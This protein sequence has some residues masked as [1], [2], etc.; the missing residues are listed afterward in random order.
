MGNLML[1]GQDRI[2]EVSAINLLSMDTITILQCMGIFYLYQVIRG[3]EH[4]MPI[5][6]EASQVGLQGHMD[7]EWNLYIQV[8]RD[9]CLCRNLSGDKITQGGIIHKGFVVVV[10]TYHY[11]LQQTLG[12]PKTNYFLTIWRLK[13]PLKIICFV[14]LTW[15][16][17]IRTWDNLCKR[18]FLSPGI[19]PLCGYDQEYVQHLLFTCTFS[20]KVWSYNFSSLGIVVT[21]FTSVELCL[22]WGVECGGLQVFVPPFFLWKIWKTQNHVIFRGK[23]HNVFYTV[24]KILGWLEHMK[25]RPT[26]SKYLTTRHILPPIIW[27]PNFFDGATQEHKCGFHAVLLMDKDLA[28]MLHWYGGPGINIKVELVTL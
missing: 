26:K 5:W 21:H 2:A 3:W 6:M 14:W 4:C 18:G 1:I 10:D 22:K 27:P 17:K 7:I 19:C 9:A 28:Y 16:N 15:K 20:M 12:T 23:L 24:A 25:L 13:I 8:L 11:I